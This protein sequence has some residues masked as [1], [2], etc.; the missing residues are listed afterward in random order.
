M[1]KKQ[2]LAEKIAK[3]IFAYGSES[4]M[5]TCEPHRI[6]YMHKDGTG[7]RMGC[8]LCESALAKVIH[9]LLK[10]EKGR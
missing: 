4:R 10:T 7:E 8:G 1:D 5:P 9:E 2:Q 6:A 3:R